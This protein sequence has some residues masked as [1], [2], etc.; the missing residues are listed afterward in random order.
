MISRRTLIRAGMA[1]PLLCPQITT[2]EAFP[3]VLLMGGAGVIPSAQAASFLA[4]TSGLSSAYQTAYVKLINGLVT[5]GIWNLLDI[6]YVPA[7]FN[8]TTATLNL[9]NANYPLVAHG[10]I[11]FTAN[12]GFRGDGSTGYLDTQYVPSTNGVNFV[13]NSASVGMYIGN[14]LFS[15]AGAAFGTNAGSVATDLLPA[16]G[17]G[18]SYQYAEL[19][20]N[21]AIFGFIAPTSGLWINSRTGSAGTTLYHN[22]NQVNAITQASSGVSSKSITL[23]AENNNGTIQSFST[24]VI[25]AFFAG[26]GLTSTQTAEMSSLL[27][28]FMIFISN[29]TY[30]GST[31]AYSNLYFCT[32]THDA[33]MVVLGTNDGATFSGPLSSSVIE[34]TGTTGTP[35]V[36]NNAGTILLVTNPSISFGPGA[37]ELYLDL[38]TLSNPGLAA[39]HVTQISYSSAIG[40]GASAMIWAA[41]WFVDPYDNSVHLF[42]GG[43]ADQS[44]DAGF[45][46]YE[47]HPTNGGYTTWSAPVAINGTSLPNNM[48]DPQV[49]YV[50]GTYYM[51]YK[52]ETTKYVEVLSG[53]S[54]TGVNNVSWSVLQSGNWAGWGSSLEAPFVFAKAGGGYRILLDAQGAGIYYSDATSWANAIAGTWTAKAAIT[55]PF[56]PQHGMLIPAPSGYSN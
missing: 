41:Q 50:S 23:G 19:N 6:L 31:G 20:A 14:N 55:A 26:A 35:T 13:Q 54:S 12:T 45:V 37:K 18:G 15:A 42:A 24:Y 56:T 22:G 2:A 4:R 8:S 27:N 25:S 33:A 46:V 36:L 21:T 39:T 29:N 9:V 49:L 53:T 17:T 5:A 43:S 7:T 28:A 34:A 1:A 32:V 40:S 30:G 47:T 44:S 48:I 52:N 51:F 10:T 16:A 11:P 38:W 3:R